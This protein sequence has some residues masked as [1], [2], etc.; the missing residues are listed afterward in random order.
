MHSEESLYREGAEGTSSQNVVADFLGQQFHNLD[1]FRNSL[2]SLLKR[3]DNKQNLLVSL[4]KELDNRIQVRT[5]NRKE[6]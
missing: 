1:E 3:T 5:K 4:K 2:E 6:K